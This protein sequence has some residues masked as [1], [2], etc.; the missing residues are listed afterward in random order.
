MSNKEIYRIRS[1]SNKNKKPG[2]TILDLNKDLN[3]LG[4]P[5]IIVDSSNPVELN[6][7]VLY[8]NKFIRYN[9]P[10][11]SWYRNI[12]NLVTPWYYNNTDIKIYINNSEGNKF[13]EIIK[14]KKLVSVRANK[15]YLHNIQQLFNICGIQQKILT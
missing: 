15:L 8:N 11:L 4:K 12:E 7:S 10:K 14:D 1:L 3:I 2:E 13:I 5:I 9:R 6:N